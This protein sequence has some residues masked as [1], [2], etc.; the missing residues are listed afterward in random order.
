MIRAADLPL[1]EL[2]DRLRAARSRRTPG[3]I[4]ELDALDPDRS[5][6]H[7]DGELIGPDRYRSWA[8]WAEVAEALDCALGTPRVPCPG[9]VTVRLRVLDRG[10]TWHA[11]AP[12]GDPEK[13]GADS[14][15][16]RIDK[17]EEPDF[18]LS[19]RRALGYLKLPAA[20]DVLSVGVHQGDELGAVDAHLGPG[21]GRVGVDHS[22]S[23]LAVAR[24]RYPDPRFTFIQADL[25]DPLPANAALA[26]GV[27][28]IVAINTLHS[29]SLDGPAVFRR[30]L[31]T[32]LRPA[33]G[34]ILGFAR[35][36]YI[37]HQR[38]FGAEKPGQVLRDVAAYRRYLNQHGFTSMVLGKHTVLLVARRLR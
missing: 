12:S 35:C 31:N 6:A 19:F 27:D 4:I 10:A 26:T 3:E 8:G 2:L 34:V 18:A 20:P 5:D 13:Y 11:E 21:G 28:A 14:A 23:A 9:R 37:E 22:S 24:Q 38:R 16:A 17:F 15:F 29:P 7:F 25:G 30:L 32:H 1:I 36:R 33:G